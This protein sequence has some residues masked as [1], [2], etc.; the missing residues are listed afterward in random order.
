MRYSV[1]VFVMVAAAVTL[2]AQP[3][4]DKIEGHNSLN[5]SFLQVGVGAGWR[6]DDSKA[7]NT[8]ITD[9][10]LL[11]A[12]KPAFLIQA[13]ASLQPRQNAYF[14]THFSTGSVALGLRLQ[15]P[16]AKVAL[17]GIF[18]LDGSWYHGETILYSAD[19]GKIV[20][21]L[22]RSTRRTGYALTGGVA[23]RA[24]NRFAIDLGLR[25]VFNDSYHVVDAP[26]PP[27]IGTYAWEVPHDL[28]NQASLFV[29]TRVGL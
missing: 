12:V 29:Q 2:H 11:V 26:I 20:G 8:L 17:F 6:F 18:E 13:R 28:Y 15:N 1:A 9:L 23:F 22:W 27:Y 16:H 24:G 14:M 19:S 4:A 21:R 25:K 7:D 5:R 3:F 10:C